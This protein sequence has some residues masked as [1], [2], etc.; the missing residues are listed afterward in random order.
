MAY[1]IKGARRLEPLPKGINIK[2]VV[3][4][5]KAVVKYYGDT[6]TAHEIR[7]ASKR[8]CSG[9][10]ITTTTGLI[11]F[12]LWSIDLSEKP[13]GQ[14]VLNWRAIVRKQTKR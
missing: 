1:L 6:I 7:L 11:E 9:L 2:H 8:A 4:V 13:H 10:N 12:L 3:E 14:E 5:I